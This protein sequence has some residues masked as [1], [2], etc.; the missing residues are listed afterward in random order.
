MADPD[1]PAL[2][3]LALVIDDPLAA[4]VL[5]A[6]RAEKLLLKQVNDQKTIATICDLADD[7]VR[8]VSAMMRRLFAAR[9]LLDG[10]IAPAAEQLLMAYVGQRLRPPKKKSTT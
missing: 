8:R 5:A 1:R 10:D 3:L 2:T 4:R 9:L 6:W 7:D